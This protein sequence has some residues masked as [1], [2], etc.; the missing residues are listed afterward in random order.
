MRTATCLESAAR[1]TWW[2]VV[3]W[4]F[5]K[6]LW[7]SVLCFVASIG[8][9]GLYA[10]EWTQAAQFKAKHAWSDPLSIEPRLSGN[11]GE[12][13]GNHFHTGID[14]KTEGREGLVILAATDGRVS[15]VKMSPWGYG[16]AL[17]LEGPDG[18]T[19]VY[20]HL[21]RFAP[22]I[23][24]WALERIYSGRHLGLDAS[25]PAHAELSFQAGDTLG[26]SGNSGS[27][28]GP[29]LHFEVRRTSD[30]HPLNPLDG[31][32]EK[33]DTR[34]PVL[35]ALWVETPK[36]MRKWPLDGLDTLRVFGPFRLSVEGY[37][38]LDG[39][40]NICGL[41]TL[42]AEVVKEGGQ[43]VLTYAASWD[44]LDF[45][46]N[47]DMNAH[48]FYP[49]WSESRDQVHRLHG[50]EANRLKIY[51]QPSTRGWLEM[52]PGEVA[53]LRI[54]ATDA[55]GNETHRRVVLTF[56]ESAGW[57]GMPKD[58][59][60]EAPTCSSG[61]N[62]SGF[63]EVDGCRVTWEGQTF[64]EPTELGWSLNDRRTG[65]VLFPSA[66]PLRKPVEVAWD[67]P[68]S[69]Q[70][71]DA[72]WSVLPGRSWPTDKW[73]AVQRDSEGEVVRTS[74]AHVKDGRVLMSLSHGGH[75]GLERDTVPPRLLPYHSGTPLVQ[76]GDAVWYV[77]DSLSGV[78]GL[79][80]TL[81]GVWARITWDPKRNMVTYSQ[82]DEVHARGK[83]VKAVLKA[84]DGAGNEKSWVGQLRWP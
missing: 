46:V 77:E 54:L 50:L 53:E 49:V 29:H 38:L 62:E 15:R 12:L 6:K 68:P 67:L 70:V 2:P 75:W 34:P 44:E 26:W 24:A 25:P 19:T 4:V 55:A 9:E 82:E 84:A 48:A 57:E 36:S 1:L 79:E 7:F 60:W 59:S 72:G 30:Q 33:V 61:V 83:L 27:S 22:R 74:S 8:A 63:W 23:E 17:Y 76:D 20:A 51:R 58:M 14:L 71:W 64:F 35:P 10:Q 66:A 40:S 31:W 81:D 80:L 37:D 73:L 78:E 5:W 11:F 32:V 21:R 43:K 69:N 13:R 65:G 47:K 3:Q 28:G 18:L 56:G 52:N 45:G 39:A 42:E 41:R 16:N